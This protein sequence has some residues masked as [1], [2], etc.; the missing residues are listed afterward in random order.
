M[1]PI[2]FFIYGHSYK[3]QPLLH[4]F[5][6][7]LSY[8]CFNCLNYSVFKYIFGQQSANAAP[9]DLF[10]TK[11]CVK[12]RQTHYVQKLIGSTSLGTFFRFS[13]QSLSQD[14]CNCSGIEVAGI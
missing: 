4:L 9:I 1:V 12:M 2:F 13:L 11:S 6:H 3:F 10:S 8:P 7:R 5:A 14:F